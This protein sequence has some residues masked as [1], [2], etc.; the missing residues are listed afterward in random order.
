MK[1]G[2]LTDYL[3]DYYAGITTY[4]LNLVKE[5]LKIDKKNDYKLIHHTKSSSEIYKN[6]REILF[7]LPPV[8]YYKKTI[9]KNFLLPRRLKK[10]NLDII[11][12]PT[13]IAPFPKNALFKKIVTILDITP[14]LFPETHPFLTKWQ[15]RR[16]IKRIRADI[17]LIITISQNTKNDLI[18]YFGVSPVK[19]KVVY[20]GV[21]KKY[22]II[23]DEDLLE[24]VR[25]K[26]NLPKKFILCVGTLE[27]RK[28]ISTL[29]RIFHFL[30][31]SQNER[32]QQEHLIIAGKRGWKYDGIF[33]TVTQLGLEKFV[34]FTDF[35]DQKDLPNLYN[36]AEVFVYPSLY[37]GFGLPPL[38]AMAC[39]CPIITS[40][41]SSLPEVAGDAA[42]MINPQNVNAFAGAIKRVLTDEN[43]R[44]EMIE[45]GLKQ[46][47]KFSWEKCAKETLKVYR[48]TANLT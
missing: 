14:Y 6:G 48:E 30:R 20:L 37:E 36:L 32:F 47:K 8:P 15:F 9:W 24:R 25:Q 12:D 7:P 5:L 18:K 39:G 1:I 2:I 10:I 41:S 16:A 19:I 38:E 26:Y 22:R 44:K 43:L 11:H 31:T 23:P 46:A 33:E 34:H 42:I 17:D 40:N 45:K 3:D 29:I 4:T 28:N 27:P 35:V 21:S 13:A